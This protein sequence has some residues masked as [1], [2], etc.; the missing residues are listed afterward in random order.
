MVTHCKI[1]DTN[2]IISYKFSG[3][4]EKVVKIQN[5]PID[6]S[7]YKESPNASSNYN[8]E[9]YGLRFYSPNNF[10]FVDVVVKAGCSSWEGG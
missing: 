1:G 9:G 3:Q 4:L 6:V 2:S 7:T 8:P 5:A 10:Q